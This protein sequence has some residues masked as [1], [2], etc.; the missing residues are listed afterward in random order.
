MNLE[1]SKHWTV[2]L[3]P[4]CSCEAMCA[5]VAILSALSQIDFMYQQ[6]VLVHID[7]NMSM[8]QSIHHKLVVLIRILSGIQI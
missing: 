5:C 6:Y 8:G 3:S 1:F 2:G 7:L 4:G